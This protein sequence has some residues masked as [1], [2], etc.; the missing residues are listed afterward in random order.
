MRLREEEG[1]LARER[2]GEKRMSCGPKGRKE[3][4]RKKEKNEE[5]R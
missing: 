5:K 3:I 4:E 1:E 2:G